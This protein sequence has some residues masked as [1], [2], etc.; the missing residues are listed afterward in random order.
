MPTEMF[1]IELNLKKHPHPYQF[2]FV[3]IVL[4]DGSKITPQKCFWDPDR[5]DGEYLVTRDEFEEGHKKQVKRRVLPYKEATIYVNAEELFIFETCQKNGWDHVGGNSIAFHLHPVCHATVYDKNRKLVV[6]DVVV[7]G[8]RGEKDQP[9]IAYFR[10]NKEHEDE[11]WVKNA[12][13][14]NID[15]CLIFANPEEIHWETSSLVWP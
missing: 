12:T 4:K 14:L 3:T 15:D 13:R 7:G 1:P 6:K 11:D 8:W 10:D 5:R 9:T 2:N